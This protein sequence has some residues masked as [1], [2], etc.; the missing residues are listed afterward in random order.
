MNVLLGV[1]RF[2]VLE[3]TLSEQRELIVYVKDR[4]RV[5]LRNSSS[6]SCVIYCLMARHVG[7][8]YVGDVGS[9][10]TQLPIDCLA[11]ETILSRITIL[12]ILGIEKK[13]VDTI[14]EPLS[15]YHPI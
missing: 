4:M 10:L 7:R 14:C 13:V 15:A 2:L 6:R 8:Q 11:L 3:S 1:Y 5:C 9:I 12:T